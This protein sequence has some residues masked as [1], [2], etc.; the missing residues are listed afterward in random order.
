VRKVDLRHR[1]ENNDYVEVVMEVTLSQQ[2][3]QSII[4]TMRQLGA[5]TTTLMSG[6]GK[7]IAY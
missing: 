7:M 1:S 2:H 6:Q 4:D 5:D 3:E